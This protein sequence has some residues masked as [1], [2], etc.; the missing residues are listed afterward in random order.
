MSYITVKKIRYPAKIKIYRRANSSNLQYYFRYSG[1][2]FR[3]SCQTEKEYIA[4]DKAIGS[5]Y[6][7]RQGIKTRIVKFS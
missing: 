1:L 7:A 3:G 2:T 5:Y 6:D 4:I